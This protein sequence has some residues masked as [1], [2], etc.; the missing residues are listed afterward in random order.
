METVRVSLY[1]SANN[2]GKEMKTFAIGDIH[3]G[4]KALKQCLNA[5]RFLYDKDKLI[6]LGDVCDGW[7]QTRQC[8]DE[9][10]QVKNLVLVMGN[11]DF[12]VLE[13]AL[14][15]GEEVPAVWFEQGGE[16]TMQSYNKQLPPEEH[17]EFLKSGTPLYI[18]DKNRVFVHGGFDRKKDPRKQN[19]QVLMWDRDLIRTACEMSKIK[20]DKPKK[21]TEFEEV[22]LGH[23]PVSSLALPM[24]LDTPVH[25]FEIW[26]LDTGG[27]WEGKLTIMDVDTHEYWQSDVVHTLYPGEHGRQG[28]Q[29]RQRIKGYLG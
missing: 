24:A 21:L 2:S 17:I 16:S 8:I 7:P 6:V 27:G 13:W 23:T 29:M 11:H 15:G 1:T 22:F 12:W 10:L 18:D 28:Q 14:S 19:Q 26:D 25:L 3:G 20:G 4:Y 9:L 5:A